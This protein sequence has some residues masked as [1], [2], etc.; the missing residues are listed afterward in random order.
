MASVQWGA[1]LLTSEKNEGHHSLITKWTK[2]DE[3]ESEVYCIVNRE[4]M[5]RNGWQEVIVA[6]RDIEACYPSGFLCSWKAGSAVTQA[7]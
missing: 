1:H 4:G 7:K 2:F 5:W 3:R 6:E